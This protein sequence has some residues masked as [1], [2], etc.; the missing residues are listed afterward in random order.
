VGTCLKIFSKLFTTRSIQMLGFVVFVAAA[1][2]GVFG[3]DPA[4]ARLELQT[5]PQDK[6]LDRPVKAKLQE[7]RTLLETGKPQ[8]AQSLLKD[9]I[10][11]DLYSRETIYNLKR[12]NDQDVSRG[13][14]GARP[15][16]NPFVTPNAVQSGSGAGDSSLYTRH[17]RLDPDLVRNALK[18]FA[19]PASPPYKLEFVISPS[20]IPGA[21]IGKNV[22]PTVSLVTVHQSI[23]AFLTSIAGVEFP[24]NSVGAQTPTTARP[25]KALFYSDRSGFLYVRATLEE[26]DKIGTALSTLRASPPQ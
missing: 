13:F 3:V 15:F 12:I 5:R 8:E 20:F 26:L 17:F 7:A 24:T 23:R 14:A 4:S 22:E 1:V 18:D 21:E 9:A 19:V 25:S 6:Y 2:T 10:K 11:L 16:G